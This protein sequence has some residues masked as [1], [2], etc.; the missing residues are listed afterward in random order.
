MWIQQFCWHT[1]KLMLCI[2]PCYSRRRWSVIPSIIS[3]ISAQN[4][5]FTTPTL[6]CCTVITKPLHVDRRSVQVDWTTTDHTTVED[7]Q[8]DH[9][10]RPASSRSI[11]GRHNVADST[12]SSNTSWPAPTCIARHDLTLTVASSLVVGGLM[13]TLLTLVVGC[14]SPGWSVVRWPGPRSTSHPIVMTPDD[15]PIDSR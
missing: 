11:G 6:L 5:H 12:T 15:P 14:W 13:S 7:Q 10:G 9:S 8:V 4:L 3:I 1:H 2:Y